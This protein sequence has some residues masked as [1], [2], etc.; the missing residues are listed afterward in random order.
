VKTPLILNE[1]SARYSAG[2]IE[3]YDNLDG[4]LWDVEASD[5]ARNIYFVFDATGREFLL[6]ANKEEIAVIDTGVENKIKLLALLDDYLN[7][8][9]TEKSKKSI[10]A[11][12]LIINE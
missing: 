5:V 12:I 3:F 11:A 6:T 8:V 10:S 7:I 4:L 1:S 9:V 2:D